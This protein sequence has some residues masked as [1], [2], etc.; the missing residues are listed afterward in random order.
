MKA[1]IVT[2]LRPL[3]LLVVVAGLLVPATGCVTTS[4]II[5]L[6]V[7]KKKQRARQ[8][9]MNFHADAT[10]VWEA[11]T[12]QFETM[13]YAA[14]KMREPSEKKR[15]FPMN[16]VV[17]VEGG[18][19]GTGGRFRTEEIR[20]RVEL[21][22]QERGTQVVIVRSD[23]DEEKFLEDL[24]KRL[25]EF[26]E[27]VREYRADLERTWEAVFAQLEEMGY[28]LDELPDLEQSEG[29]LRVDGLRILVEDLDADSEAKVHI[30][31][32]TFDSE[33]DEELALE[34]LRGVARE[35]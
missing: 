2:Y 26:S 30:R 32:G 3:M 22:S 31:V 23:F 25:G 15:K 27:A 34:F 21:L 16:I 12:A 7:F 13:G 9:K 4:A 8:V 33:A 28:E 5:Y 17:K 14:E 20:V 11:A 6:K 24:G 19:V 29:R 1:P 10:T 18:Y 35:L